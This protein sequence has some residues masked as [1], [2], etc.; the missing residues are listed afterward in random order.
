MEAEGKEHMEPVCPG[1]DSCHEYQI[2][3]LD[4]TEPDIKLNLK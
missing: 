2:I 1:D 4:E 3:H